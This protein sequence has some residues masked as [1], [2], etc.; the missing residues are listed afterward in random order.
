[1]IFDAVSHSYPAYPIFCWSINVGLKR[2]FQTIG[3]HD[4]R[5]VNL[6]ELEEL[7]MPLPMTRSKASLLLGKGASSF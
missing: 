4:L 2:A 1:M 7:A 5:W 3:C 6:R